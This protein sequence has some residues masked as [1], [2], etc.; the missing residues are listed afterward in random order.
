[1]ADA[2]KTDAR[3]RVF[4]RLR[5]AKQDEEHLERERESQLG[6]AIA[7]NQ[8]HKPHVIDRH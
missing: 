4:A 3:V 1:M 6:I 7:S 2:A 8:H 5:P